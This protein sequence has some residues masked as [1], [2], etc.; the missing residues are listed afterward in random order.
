MNSRN[1]RIGTY[2]A[3]LALA[4]GL[5]GYSLRSHSPSRGFIQPAPQFSLANL[6]GKQVGLKDFTNKVIVVDF[7]ATWCGPCREEIP[8]LNKLYEDYR[9][10][11]FEI[12]GISMDTDDPDSIKKF[13]RDLRMEYTVVIGNDSVAQDFGGVMGLPTKFIIDR[14]GNI[15]KKFT[16]YNPSI[17][18]EIEETIRQLAG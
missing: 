4:V 15:V 5:A 7:W 9:G 18:Q 16:G 3:A 13:A 6:E 14:K 8:H 10:K 1:F 17:I 2:G 12:V 11:G